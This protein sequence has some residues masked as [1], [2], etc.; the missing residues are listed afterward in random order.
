MPRGGTELKPGDRVVM[1]VTAEGIEQFESLAYQ[2][3]KEIINALGSH[4]F[5][6]GLWRMHDCLAD[7]IALGRQLA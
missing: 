1:F 6:V 7:V 3:R 4:P 5:H 2:Q